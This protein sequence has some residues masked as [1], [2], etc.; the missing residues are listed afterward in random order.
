MVLERTMTRLDGSEEDLSLYKGK[1]VMLVNVASK[2][3][4]TP[5]YKGLQALY[6]RYGPKGLVIL[7]FPANDFMGQEPG[8]DEEIG[9]FC[10]LNF[11]V[12]FPLFSKISVKGEAMHP[13]Y[14]EITTMPE[15]IGGDVLWN[16]QKYLLNKS[17][18]VVRKI[19]PQTKPEDP[20]VSAAI[21]ALLEE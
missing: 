17:G 6:D 19:G 15:P 11:G 8:T 10:E 16:F 12:T 3:G 2:C 20:E 5:Q 4:L 21:E 18:D 13:L 1:V 14:R 7:G 9:Q